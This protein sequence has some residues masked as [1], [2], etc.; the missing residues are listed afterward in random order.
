MRDYKLI[1]PYMGVNKAI[2]LESEEYLLKLPQG[3]MKL[4]QE[5][6][7]S[8]E[9]FELIVEENVEVSIEEYEPSDEIKRFKLELIIKCSDKERDNIRSFLEKN[10]M[11]V[12]RSRI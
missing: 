7:D 11:Y 1:K 4:K 10:I 2:L 6:L 9:F 12:D 5:F 8:S 3:S